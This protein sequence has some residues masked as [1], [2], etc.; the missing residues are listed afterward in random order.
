M[1]LISELCLGLLCLMQRIGIP[2][3]SDVNAFITRSYQEKNMGVVLVKGITF[4]YINI[5]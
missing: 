3:H 5:L 4:Y 2:S 1:V